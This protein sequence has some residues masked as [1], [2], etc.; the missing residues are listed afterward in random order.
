MREVLLSPNS[1]HQS[2]CSNARGFH[3]TWK[4]Q[5][6]LD[7]Q[8]IINIQGK[9]IF[10]VFLYQSN[11]F[12]T[13]FRNKDPPKLTTY[14]NHKMLSKNNLV[15]IWC[16]HSP[17]RHPIFNIIMTNVNFCSSYLLCLSWLISMSN[18]NYNQPVHTVDVSPVDQE[19]LWKFQQIL[20][21]LGRIAGHAVMQRSA[22]CQVMVVH[23]CPH[24]D[25]PLEHLQVSS[26]NAEE[27][28]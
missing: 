24:V 17:Y 10:E 13:I 4:S 7:Y 3:Q 23:L 6:P 28:Y 12:V 15:N 2:Q 25:Q 22:A 5:F 9:V 21:S 27:M 19:H 16:W 26:L 11:Q 20:L 18:I 8:N 1:F 14:L